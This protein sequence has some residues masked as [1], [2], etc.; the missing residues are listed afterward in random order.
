MI[1]PQISIFDLESDKLRKKVEF[2]RSPVFSLDV[3]G[4]FLFAGA[5][6]TV[7]VFSLRSMEE[8]KPSEYTPT[9]AFINHEIISFC[10]RRKVNTSGIIESTFRLFVLSDSSSRM[11]T[12]DMKITV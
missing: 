5:F 2:K 12:F 6:K 8:I 3:I 4:R 7:R 11:D 10:A 1:K 9:T